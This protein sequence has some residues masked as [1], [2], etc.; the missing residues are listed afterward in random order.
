MHWSLYVAFGL[1]YLLVAFVAYVIMV[2]SDAEGSDEAFLRSFLWPVLL[3]GAIGIG[4]LAVVISPFLLL[5]KLFEFC[6]KSLRR[7]LA[8]NWTED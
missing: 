8:S 6:R 1:I 5:Q 2:S 3:A 7:K 4:A